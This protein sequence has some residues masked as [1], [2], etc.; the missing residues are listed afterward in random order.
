MKIALSTD[1][2]GLEQLGQL[3]EYLEG[4]G[5]ECLNFG[6]TVVDPADDYPDFIRP[7]AEA[8]AAGQAEMGIIMG[9]SGQGEA[10]VANRVKGVRCVVYYG[11]ATPFGATEAEGSAPADEYEIIRLSR[12]HNN[13]NM[14]SIAA[15]FVP[16]EEIKKVAK[17]WLET[18]FKGA[19]RHLRR[20]A[21][22]DQPG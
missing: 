13:A 14:L 8:V 16:Q 17:L 15:R 20:I 21:K 12:T 19:E 3:Q 10:Q 22:L 9:G 4:L 2:A 5:H 1:H 6:P 7:A 11:P 18:E